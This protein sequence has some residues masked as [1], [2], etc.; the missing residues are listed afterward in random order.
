[1]P[2]GRF[3]ASSWNSEIGSDV[4]IFFMLLTQNTITKPPID[5]HK[6]LF[7]ATE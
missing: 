6:L 1:V 7:W 5:Q 3:S 2:T 4:C